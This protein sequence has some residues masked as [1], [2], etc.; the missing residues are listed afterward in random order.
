MA[1][2][3][4]NK[5]V[6]DINKA[7]ESL[8]VDTKL[9]TISADEM[10]ASQSPIR[11]EQPK[12]V[13]IAPIQAPAEAVASPYDTA[14]LQKTAET[15]QKTA[16]E[17]F[18][19]LIDTISGA[20]GPTELTA[21]AEEKAGLPQAE[22]DL[23]DINDQLRN[24]QRRLENEVR[25]IQDNKAGLVGPAVGDK[26]REAQDR[27]YR[28]QADMA[29]IQQSLQGRYDSAKTIAD[30]AVKIQTERQQ[31]RIDA[32]QLTY[33]R[34]KD[35][36]TKDEQRAFE[37]AQADRQ[38]VLD[39]EAE[40]R[41]DIKTLGLLYLKEGGDP[42]TAAAIMSSNTYK[43]AMAKTGDIIGMTARLKN[44]KLIKTINGVGT[45]VL[46]GGDKF[47][48]EVKLSNEYNDRTADYNK[49][50]VQI[51]NIKSSYNK[52][53]NDVASGKSIN[54]ASQGV[55]VAF[56]KLI[57]PGS[58]VRE[59]EYARSS[60]GLSLLSQVE[61]YVSKLSQGGAGVTASDLK[62][63]AETADIL[64]RGYED[65]AIEQA[66]LISGQ[67]QPYGLNIQSI[68]PQ[69]VFNLMESRLEE[70]MDAAQIG[71]TFQIGSKVYQKVGDNDFI[72]VQ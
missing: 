14:S 38:R 59:S 56:Q 45:D 16:D 18:Q 70:G 5:Q 19:A 2:Q 17:S 24:E 37:S 39:E 7:S 51:E 25:D 28:R 64:L 58:V 71:D 10:G 27:S 53:L 21:T 34:N 11:V 40:E 46:E 20:T 49:A 31:A 65:Y 9:P 63:F 44:E 3:D 13:E 55:L 26:I 41:S 12:T 35:L 67:A 54:A 4:I 36:F 72:E 60:E 1:I 69:G 30:R 15:E 47:N 23:Q 43:D 42:Q 8:G 50:S 22:K 62:E 66:Q 61:G 52:A 6:E 48:A 29:V 33:E 32:L 68:I 57:D